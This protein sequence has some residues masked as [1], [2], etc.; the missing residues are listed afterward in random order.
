MEWAGFHKARR[1][2][3]T[4]KNK[5]TKKHKLTQIKHNKIVISVNNYENKISLFPITFY[6][7]LVFGLSINRYKIITLQL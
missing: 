3:K 6:C 1:K 4:F 5:T 2:N 7:G